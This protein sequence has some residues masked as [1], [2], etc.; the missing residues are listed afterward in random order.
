MPSETHT[1]HGR[2]RTS[3]AVRHHPVVVI[4]C[5]AIGA[6][7]GVLYAAS[8]PA[9][10][11]STATVLVNPSVGNPFVPTPSSVRQDELTSLETE[12]QVA[13][14]AEVLGTV[15]GEY[16]TLQASALSHNLQIVVPPNSQ[17]LAISYSAKDPVKAQLIANAVADAYLANRTHRFSDVND[18]QIQRLSKQT[19][20]VQDSMKEASRAAQSGNAGDRAFETQLATALRNQLVSLRAQRTVLENSDVPAGSVISPAVRPHAGTNLMALAAPIGGALAGLSLGCLIA[21]LMEG[22]AGSIR[23]PWEVEELGLPVAAAVPTS[24]MPR[25]LRR[26]DPEAFAIAI[27]RLRALILDLD[28]RPDV[29]SVAPPGDRPSEADVSEAVAE[30]FAKAGHRV[31]L[32]RADD[33]SDDS[34]GLVVEDGLAQA[35][36]YERLNVMELLESS[37]E[38]LL[39]V[40][41]AGRSN[42]Q[43]REFLTSERLRSVLAPLVE[44]G[45]TVVIESPG[46]GT[47]EGDAVTGASDLCLV[48]VTTRRTRTAAVAAFVQEIAAKGTPVAA[49]VV[50]PHDAARRDRLGPA[51]EDSASKAQE[52]KAS[53]TQT[54]Q[55]PARSKR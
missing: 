28:P 53:T 9:T 24:R 5:L 2:N 21:L 40:L 45:N 10:Y 51:D 37:R 11:T 8:L 36:L 15:L 17:T 46:L 27:R 22:L 55:R 20:Q 31:V 48:A 33:R 14:S 38:P 44:A 7:L 23:A 19:T 52:T 41:P 30:S 34:D 3:R 32:V 54:R 42:A 49:L 18:A 25:L 43:S 13:R 39:C 4:A 16:P 50:G 29:I 35:L 6:L 47:V 26:H 1:T 12:A